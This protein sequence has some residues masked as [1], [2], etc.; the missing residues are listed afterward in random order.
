M[1][2]IKSII[3]KTIKDEKLYNLAV[4]IDESYV[5]N[6]IVVH[7]CRSTLTPI[8]KYEEYEPDTHVGKTPIQ[9]FIEK[10]IGK[11]FA[12]K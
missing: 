1:S 10:N 12:T 5:A 11:G 6:D 9:E 2:R 4:E 8:T 3:K 7:N